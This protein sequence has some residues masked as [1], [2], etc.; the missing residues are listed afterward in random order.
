MSE[1][2]EKLTPEIVEDFKINLQAK[3]ST[4]KRTLADVKREV[5]KE[6]DFFYEQSS[7]L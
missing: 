7:G 6:L 2:S 1:K 3:L 4:D 5:K